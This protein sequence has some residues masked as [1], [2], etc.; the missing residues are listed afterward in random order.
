VRTFAEQSKPVQQTTPT[1]S[2]IRSQASVGRSRD[3]SIFHSPAV[4][5]I[6]TSRVLQRKT[7]NRAIESSSRSGIPG[8][9]GKRRHLSRDGRQSVPSVETETI[10]SKI[11]SPQWASTGRP[12]RTDAGRPLDPVM[13]LQMEQRFA[14]DFSNVRVH[15]DQR[16]AESAL[17]LGAWAYTVGSDIFFGEG[18]RSDHPAGRRLLA[19]ELA[20]VVQVG[21]GRSAVAGGSQTTVAEADAAQA[22]DALMA[23]SDPV[24]PTATAPPDAVLRQLDP[25]AGPIEEAPSAPE[26]APPTPEAQQA[27]PINPFFATPW[28]VFQRPRLLTDELR[29][30]E[31]VDV[32]QPTF[33]ERLRL[34]IFV[35]DPVVADAVS[36]LLLA[37]DM[38]SGTPQV[39]AVWDHVVAQ[40]KEPRS[41]PRTKGAPTELYSPPLVAA[42][43]ALAQDKKV[44]LDRQAEVL[45]R[46]FRHL[47]TATERR[48]G[49][50]TD[51]FGSPEQEWEEDLDPA[52]KQHIAG[53][54]DTYRDLRGALLASF[55]ALTVGTAAVIEKINKYYA[56]KIV[57]VEFLGHNQLVHTDLRD[58]LKRAEGRLAEPDRIAIG[59][60]I[61]SFGG[62]NIRRNT[63]NPLRLSEHSFGAA[64]DIN[65]ELNPNVPKFQV[66]FIEEVTGVDL[67]TTAEGR[68][69][70]DVFDLGEVLEILVFGKK[71]PALLELER[72]LAASEQLVG[73]FKDDASLAAGMMA[74]AGRM[75]QIRG[76]VKSAALLA[77]AR[78]A[79]AEGTKVRW[80][81][82]DPKLRL[83][84]N[85]PEGVKHN[86][87]VD[88]VFPPRTGSWYPEPLDVWETKRHAVELLIQMVDVYERSF[89]RDKKG[90]LVYKGGVPTRIVPRARAP[91]GEAALPQLVAHGFVNLAAKLVSA[92]RAPD[93]G[94]LRWLGVSEHTKDFMHFELKKRPPLE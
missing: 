43:V 94:N 67:L 11:E 22:A 19:H 83:P 42:L 73:I 37:L 4:I 82:Q 12:H 74:V 52:V 46:V 90:G 54:L 33:L 81:Y 86:A 85:A 76:A 27:Q 8:Y 34:Q 18:Y 20:H 72:L 40:V 63:N 2:T 55:G 68:R 29:R 39:A 6:Q 62:I 57:P 44:A 84:K 35:D 50:E 3:G 53:G 49:N 26:A 70:T 80:M 28:R 32:L 1:K 45:E 91:E 78:D 65:P 15:C 88:L 77:A 25:Q 23:T 92:L 30:P 47:L 10:G 14:Y 75:T 36:R 71:D 21:A 59:K 51:G 38:Y 58:A 89:M 13:R 56:G 79:R 61:T 69:K 93:G 24:H 9:S 5:P 87:L 66:R 31:I 7:E 48:L 17:R 64:I 41:R 60:E 16:A